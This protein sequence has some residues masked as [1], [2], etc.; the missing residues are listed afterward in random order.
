MHGD[1]ESEVDP[2]LR[3]LS[4]VVIPIVAVAAVVMLALLV[5]G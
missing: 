2:L 4:G 5:F 3:I 1:D